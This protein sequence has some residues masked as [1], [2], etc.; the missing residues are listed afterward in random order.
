MRG[1]ARTGF[2]LLETVVALTLFAGVLLS[3]IGTG[4]FVLARMYENDLR[5]RTTQYANSLIDSLRGTACS[6]LAS[7]QGSRG[8]LAATWTVTDIRDIARIDVAITVPQRHAAAARVKRA[9]TL[10]SC[11]EP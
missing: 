3:L 10:L 6:R 5:F 2:S 4:Q 7:G 8:A 9:T 11:P 1:V